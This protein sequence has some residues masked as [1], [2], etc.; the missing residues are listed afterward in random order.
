MLLSKLLQ[1]WNG[2]NDNF[3]NTVEAQHRDYL[4]KLGELSKI[5]STCLK[6]VS[7]ERASLAEFERK[8]RKVD[9]LSS[10]G[11]EDSAKFHDLVADLAERKNRLDDMTET[12]PRPNS[13]FYLN[14]ILGSIDVSILNKADKFRYKDDYEKFK[15]SVTVVSTLV[16]VLCYVFHFRA[17]DAVFHFLLVW[18]YCTL[19]IRES[20]LRC[21]GSRIKGWWVVHHYASTVLC[22]ILLTWPDGVCYQQFRKQFILFCFYI[23]VVQLMQGQY[24]RGCLYRL[25][26]LG[27]S[28]SMDITVEGFHSWMFRGL[29]FLLPFLLFGYV[30][31]VYNAYT[32]WNIMAENE[33]R[34]WQVVAVAMLFVMLAVGNTATTAVVCLNKLTNKRV[35]G[36]RHRLTT[37]Y[38]LDQQ[39]QQSEAHGRSKDE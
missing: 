22:G 5:Q 29:T 34:E 7:R 36:H 23:G 32:L 21:N 18:Y 9:G 3:T 28:H 24:Q 16:A 19:T 39:Q 35:A 11:D 1:E 20:V 30:L 6:N 2:N 26:A 27:M 10:L 25:R 15:I 14:L 4:V 12:L 17:L 33:C 13:G 8:L 38:Q 31:Q 37:K